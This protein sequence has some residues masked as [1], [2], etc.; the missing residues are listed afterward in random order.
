MSHYREKA[1]NQPET[2]R[3]FDLNTFLCQFLFDDPSLEALSTT[4][5][6]RETFKEGGWAFLL[7]KNGKKRQK[8]TANMETISVI[9][10]SKCLS[11]KEGCRKLDILMENKAVHLRVLLTIVEILSF[12]SPKEQTKKS[13]PK[14]R[15][16]LTVKMV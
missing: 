1:R 10:I 6:K 15:K 13:G 3:I 7:M 11:Q 8:I 5:V 4:K 16:N 14:F 12:Y 9:L 2:F